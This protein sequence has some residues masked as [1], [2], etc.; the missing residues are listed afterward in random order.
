MTE[1][2]SKTELLPFSRHLVAM[3]RFVAHTAGRPLGLLSEHRGS[4]RPAARITHLHS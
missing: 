2:K 3:L 1:S 4:Q